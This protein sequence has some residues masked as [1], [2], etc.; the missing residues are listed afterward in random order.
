MIGRLKKLIHDQIHGHST[1]QELARGAGIGML[2]ALTPFFGFQIAV[3]LFF[4]WLFRANKAIAMTMTLI[5]NPWTMLP[6]HYMQGRLAEVVVQY[7]RPIFTR[8]AV[9]DLFLNHAPEASLVE[10]MKTIVF[11]SQSREYF[12]RILVGSVISAIPLS[13]ASYAFVLRFST[14]LQEQ[15]RKAALA[16]AAGITKP[17]RRKMLGKLRRKKRKGIAAPAMDAGGSDS[18]NEST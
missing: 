16:R 10:W 12:K 15:K 6:V 5:T 17:K 11:G 1:P 4:A 14:E 7:E 18:K 3:A 2:V 13:L 9:E 8:E